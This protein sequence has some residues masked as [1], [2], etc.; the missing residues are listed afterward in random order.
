MLTTRTFIS[1]ACRLSH[2]AA[3]TTSIVGMSPAAARITSGSPPSS[4]LAHRQTDAPRAQCSRAVSMSS[5]W[6]WGCLSITMR[7]T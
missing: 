4:L 6:S 2:H 7:F 1:G 3:A 5:H